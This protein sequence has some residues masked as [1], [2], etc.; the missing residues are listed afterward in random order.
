[1]SESV[2]AC[3]EILK[4]LLS[5]KHAAYAWPFYKPVD[6]TALELHDYKKVCI[7]IYFRVNLNK[8]LGEEEGE[9]EKLAFELQCLH[10]FECYVGYLLDSFG[11]LLDFFDSS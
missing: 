11:I 10:Y 2:K 3:N 5:K 4:E 1:M 9:E 8:I 6:T 7:R